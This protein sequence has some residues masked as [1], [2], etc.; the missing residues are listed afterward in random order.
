MN[1]TLLLCRF[2]N[3]FT[4]ENLGAIGP[5]IVILSYFIYLLAGDEIMALFKD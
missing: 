2:L 1:G 3:D 4:R 5:Y